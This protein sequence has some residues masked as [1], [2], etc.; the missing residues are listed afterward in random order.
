[1]MSLSLDNRVAVVTGAGRGIGRA[2]AMKLAEMGASVVVN[3][4]GVTIEGAGM[5]AS[6]AN[7]VTNEIKANGGKAVANHDSVADFESAKRIIETAVNQFGKIDIL[8]NNA[9]TTAGAPIYELDPKTFA[10]VVGVHLFGTFNCTR[11]ACVYMKDQG[12][13]RI[14]NMVSRAGLWGSPGAAP[15]GSGKGGIFGFTNVVCRDLAPFGI[16]VNGVNPAAAL[17]RMVT[18]SVDRAKER[19]LDAA[20][21]ERM[22][23]VAQEPEDV[24][25]VVAFLCTEEAGA[26]NGQY[27]FVQGGSVGLFQP[28]TVTKTAFK[29][30]RWTL[31]ELAK[32]A[33]TFE[34]PEL[35]A[36]Y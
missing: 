13:G 32:V 22:L 21:A 9:G 26:I 35:K 6:P 10:S 29:D 34:I 8:V 1:M 20:Q 25:V 17:T 15:Y 2:V 16:T 12:W 33:P 36:L 5:D 7:Q 31:E 4:L 11:H 14:V 23:A 28:L 27:F 3:D 18:E 24:A 19:G 30:G